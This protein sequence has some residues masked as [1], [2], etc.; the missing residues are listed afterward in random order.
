MT[1]VIITAALIAFACPA[2]AAELPVPAGIHVHDGDTIG[3]G[4]SRLRIWGL[5]AAELD[6]VGG[7]ASRDYLR[8]LIRGK[9]LACDV[10]DVDFYGRRVVRCELPDGRDVA[11]EMIRAGQATEYRRYS[12]GAYRRCG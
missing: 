6:E 12:G 4:K 1:R 9:P 8:Q 3:R 2:L 10:M 11:C 5:D 7:I